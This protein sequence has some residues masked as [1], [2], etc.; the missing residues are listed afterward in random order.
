LSLEG[1]TSEDAY[2]IFFFLKE[3]LTMAKILCIYHGNCADGFG[4]AWVVR[5]F[6]GEN[7]PKKEIEFMAG[8]YQTPPPDV[9]GLDVIMVD[10]SYKRPVIEEML[11]VCESLT[12]IDHHKSAIEDLKDFNEPTIGNAPA[13][14]AKITTYFDIDHSGAMLTWNYYYEDFPPPPILLR[15]EDRDLWKFKYSDTRNIQANL[16]SYPYVFEVWDKFMNLSDYVEGG[17]DTQSELGK[18]ADE[19]AAIERKHFKDI[20]ELLKVG[21]ERM[22]ICGYNIPV[23]NLPYTMSSD[24]GNIMAKGEPFSACWMGTP[25]GINFSLRSDADNPGSIDVSMIAKEFGGGGHKNAAGFRVKVWDED[26]LAD[27]HF[28]DRKI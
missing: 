27:P 3:N 21:Q 12:I 2:P 1:A 16:F 23:C 20:Y 8:V 10:F 9:T 14:L 6:F 4:A 28:Y 5:K 15:I 17:V 22:D 7:E 26:Y 11:K 19:G 25:S 13:N 18:F 24:A